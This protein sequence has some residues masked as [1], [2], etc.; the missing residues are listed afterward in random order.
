MYQAGG[1]VMSSNPTVNVGDWYLDRDK[2]D[3]LCVIG[4]NDDEGVVDVRDEYGDI[5]EIEFDEW[6]TMDLVL[7][8]TPREWKSGL[9]WEAEEG[10]G[11]E[12]ED[13]A[14]AP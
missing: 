7:C 10:D 12:S 1:E 2:H 6:E 13:G 4:V 3:F 9:E 5:D 14:R 8:S 11:M